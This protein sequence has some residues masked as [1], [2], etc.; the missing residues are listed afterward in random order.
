MKNIY[1]TGGYGFIGSHFV[2]Q[3][4]NEYC[5]KKDNNEYNIYV[6]DSLT[7][8]S[9]EKNLEGVENIHPCILDLATDYDYLNNIFK[10]NNPDVIFHFAAES[11]VDKSI[12]RDSGDI[13]MQSNIMGTY[14]LLKASYPYRDKVMF[15]YI[16]TDEVYGQIKKG[17]F[18]ETDILQPRNVYAA[19]KGCGEML[20]RAFH[21]TYNM[22]CYI[23]RSCN[24]FG[25]NQHVEKL[26]PKVIMNALNNKKIPVYGNGCN[27][28]EWIFA[29]DNVRAIIYFYK[30]VLQNNINFD[31]INIGSGIEMTNIELVKMILKKLDK[32][33]SLIKFVTDRL[34]HD[35]R[36]SVNTTKLKSMGFKCNYD[37]NLGLDNT[38]KYYKENYGNV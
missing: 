1:I 28:R 27:I 20:V 14:N 18:Q 4:I 25:S 8:A 33:E 12:G 22:K 3:F 32:P 34:S 11:M 5:S 37:L 6:V 23:T 35:F 19:T 16:S 31:I 29:K 15:F 17:S 30:Y 9:D 13:F 26:I 24:N 2:K 36:Y 10:I 38:I 7:Y 21:E